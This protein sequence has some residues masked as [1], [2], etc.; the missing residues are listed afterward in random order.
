LSAPNKD[1]VMMA[2]RL[3][4]FRSVELVAKMNNSHSQEQSDSSKSHLLLSKKLLVATVDAVRCCTT[5]L[6]FASLFLEVGRQVEPS[7]LP[8]LFPLPDKS[9][10]WNENVD[11][12]D[13]RSVVELLTI[14]MEKRALAAS[15]SALPL[16]TSKTSARHYCGIILD[17]AI[18][19][20][21]RNTHS[22]SV[23]YDDTDEDRRVIGDLFRFGLKLEDADMRDGDSHSKMI[24]HA[25]REK[26]GDDNSL[27]SF[28]HTTGSRTTNDDDSLGLPVAENA[29]RL[30]CGLNGSNS[31]LNYIVPTNIRGVKDKEREEDAIR[32]E[33]STFIRGSLD[34]PSLG[35]VTLPN[36][37]DRSIS[38]HTIDSDIN[39]VG[40]LIGDALLELLQSSR[41]DCSWKAMG[42]LAK[43][44]FQNGIGDQPSF[45]SVGRIAA[46]VDAMDVLTIIPEA[47]TGQGD[48]R[49]TLEAYMSDEIQVCWK[50]V[51]ETTART[52]AKMSIFILE[53]LASLPLPD[54]GDQVV[55]QLG[56]VII[57]LI[58][59]CR[60][61][62]SR[63]ILGSISKR[64]CI[65]R[66]CYESVVSK[67]PLRACG[68]CSSG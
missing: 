42:A 62:L 8:H 27:N 6:Q 3:L 36:W 44:L 47:F 10:T 29:S 12:L 30:I 38:S 33:A 7:C 26:Q 67:C 25:S 15:A 39:S 63:E 4:I 60:G 23:S 51:S 55:M 16:L 1:A 59:G 24:K 45:E 11:N 32:R 64:D 57:V 54:E 41:T 18:D 5:A 13:I 14:C 48:C 58:S 2:L 68:N 53:R 31:I 34:D 66:R 20:F 9:H 37:D 46:N 43:M 52:I 56:L 17:E 49:E 22:R 40:G 50:Q 65:L 21:V 35:F 61:E 28:G 19:S